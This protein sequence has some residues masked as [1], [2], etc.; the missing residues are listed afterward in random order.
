MEILLK[1]GADPNI[2]DLDGQTPLH[3]AAEEGS[4]DTVELLLKRGAERNFKSKKGLLFSDLVS[5]SLFFIL[6]SF[7]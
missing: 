4:I 5:F 3:W 2:R 7:L 1:A 6:F